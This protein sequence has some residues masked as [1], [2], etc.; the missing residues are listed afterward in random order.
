MKER[1][2]AVRILQIFRQQQ[3]SMMFQTGDANVYQRKKTTGTEWINISR[4]VTTTSNHWQ[5]SFE[6]EQSSF[7]QQARCIV[8]VVASN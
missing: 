7:G 4:R 5:S 1:F 6:S 8:N 2:D 3:K